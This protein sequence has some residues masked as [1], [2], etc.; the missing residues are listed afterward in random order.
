M[1][2][3]DFLKFLELLFNRERWCG[4]REN[5]THYSFEIVLVD[6]PSYC[7]KRVTYSLREKKIKYRTKK[8]RH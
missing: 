8:R 2:W 1:T 5:A 7:Y 4:I 3:G 6:K